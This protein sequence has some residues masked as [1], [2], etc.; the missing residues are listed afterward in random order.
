[1]EEEI[2]ISQFL[3]S[4]GRITQLPQKF[5]PRLAVLAYLAEKF[6]QGCFYS[7]RQVN[8][9][10]DRWHTFGD[11]FVLRRELVDY[12]FLNRER[13]GSRYWRPRSEE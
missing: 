8:E 1:M 6:E 10:C 3:D 9:I 5:K 13:D 11:Y 7:E 4:E 12:N 2:K